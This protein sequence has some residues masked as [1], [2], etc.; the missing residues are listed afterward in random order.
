MHGTRNLYQEEKVS[1]RIVIDKCFA[2][3]YFLP[4]DVLRKIFYS[5]NY[6]SRQINLTSLEA[7]RSYFTN[8]HGGMPSSSHLISFRGRSGIV[9]GKVLKKFSFL[10]A[11]K[12]VLGSQGIRIKSTATIFSLGCTQMKSFFCQR[13]KIF[14][15]SAPFSTALFQVLSSP[16]HGL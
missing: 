1:Y 16:L 15:L 2:L 6:Y 8:L 9:Q 3:L 10:C 11:L 5:I 7:T 13:G 12:A 14:F 4:Q